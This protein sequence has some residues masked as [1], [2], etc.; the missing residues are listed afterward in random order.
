MLDPG[1]VLRARPSGA[2]TAGDFAN[3]T[4]FTDA[5][6][7]THADLGGVLIEAKTFPGWDRF[8]AFAAHLRFV[9]DHQQ[10]VQ[11]VAIVSDSPIARAVQMLA[12]P[13]SSALIRHFAFG[14]SEGALHWLRHGV[15]PMTVPP[16]L[17]FVDVPS[18]GTP[19]TAARFDGEQ[20]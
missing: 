11:R 7:A 19:V 12:T 15:D 18:T 1:G 5:Y 14:Q 9:H 3:L 20:T 4:R 16:P 17:Q 10:R 2:L 8:A 13:F 6:L